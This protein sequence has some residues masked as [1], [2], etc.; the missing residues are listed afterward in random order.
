VVSV[1]GGCGKKIRLKRAAN[2]VARKVCRYFLGKD[3]DGEREEELKSRMGKGG[4][5]LASEA[6]RGHGRV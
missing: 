4:D 2:C 3:E 1:F 6:A 5:R